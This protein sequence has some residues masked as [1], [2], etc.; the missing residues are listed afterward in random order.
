M[1]GRNVVPA[2]LAAKLPPAEIYSKALFATTAQLDASKAKITGD[3]DK[4]VNVNVQ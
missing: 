1:V 2:D 4:I 3:W